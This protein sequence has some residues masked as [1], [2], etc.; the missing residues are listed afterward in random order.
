MRRGESRKD[1]LP[2]GLGR[3]VDAAGLVRDVQGRVW[4]PQALLG[5]GSWGT[6]Y[7]LE[8]EDGAL[9]VLKIP[10]DAA[11]LDAADD[12]RGLAAACAAAATALRGDLESGRWPFLPRLLGTVALRDGTLGLLV[13]RYGASLEARLASGLP[14]VD[15]VELVVRVARRLAGVTAGGV[16][17]GNLRPSNV[18]LDEAGEPVLADPLVEPLAP[19]FRALELATGR[20]SYLPPE[21]PRGR[22]DASLDTW[23]LCLVLYRAAVLPGGA[24]DGATRRLDL[25]REGLGRVQLASAKDAAAARLKAERANKRFASRAVT[26]LGTVL[27]RGLSPE[28]EPSPP[29][30][31]RTAAELLE[32]VVEIDELLRPGIESVSRL[33]LGSGAR[34]GV[35]EGSDSVAFSVNVGATAGVTAHDDLAVG[36]QLLDRDA[37]GDGR[38]RISDARFT[39]DRYPSGKWRFEFVLPDVPPGRYHAKTAF[40][41]KDSG[42]DPVV[43]EGDFEV[44]P[45]PGYVPPERTDEG[46]PAAIPLPTSGAPRIAPIGASPTPRAA[47]PGTQAPRREEPPRRF[48]DDDDDPDLD[49]PPPGAVVELAALRRA[50]A[51]PVRPPEEPL[52]EADD[53]PPVRRPPIALPPRPAGIPVAVPPPAP[54]AVRAVA[55]VAE[56]PAWSPPASTSPGHVPL[57]LTPPPMRMEV[58]TTPATDADPPSLA[59]HPGVHLVD[60]DL[61]ALDPLL[62]DYPPPTQP[63]ASR[64]LTD[65]PAYDDEPPSGP[66]RL[67]VLRDRLLSWFRAD[68]GLAFLMVGSAGL[69]VISML[70]FSLKSC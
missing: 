44:R 47:V 53:A 69:V 62:S 50:A 2:E 30:R 58:P 63:G 55:P 8:G 57:R 51:R 13:P 34:D 65:L 26:R 67:E 64:A 21:P 49:G 22:V 61:E 31:F 35:F 45:R 52:P 60:D 54:V 24:D 32:R 25:P 36:V 17:H 46:V 38:V 39:V 66:S 28:L 43:A 3:V 37:P 10:H 1:A 33:M 70:F 56:A 29:Y 27:N 48:D 9:A 5:R 18:F 11:A 40:A 16:V 14:L 4:T 19:A 23:A 6:S 68:P 59:T 15:T 12:P 7:A 41:V 20:G 42:D